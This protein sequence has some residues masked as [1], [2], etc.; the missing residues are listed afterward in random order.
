MKLTKE[1]LEERIDNSITKLR[2][3]ISEIDRADSQMNMAIAA[4]NFNCG[5]AWESLRKLKDKGITYTDDK[6]Y[7]Y[8]KQLRN[9]IFHGDFYDGYWDINILEKLWRMKN[10]P[11]KGR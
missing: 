5:D 4:Y 6:T 8:L 11:N 7:E 1:E 3:S 10:E 9:K 2:F